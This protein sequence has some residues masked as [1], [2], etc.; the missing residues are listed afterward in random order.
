[1]GLYFL[2]P[3]RNDTL[4]ELQYAVDNAFTVD[5]IVTHHGHTELA[6]G[7]AFLKI[8]FGD[9]DPKLA[10]H[11]ISNAVNDLALVFDRF[12]VGEFNYHEKH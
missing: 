5:A 11:P 12:E 3:P 6:K 10:I 7:K 4:D 8:H 1:M 9:T 2:H